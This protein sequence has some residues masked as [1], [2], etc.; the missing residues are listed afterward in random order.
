M[1]DTWRI[2]LEHQGFVI[3]FEEPSDF[4][5]VQA[6]RDAVGQ[7]LF[8]LIDNAIK[9]SGDSKHIEV[10]LGHQDHQAVIEVVDQG[11]GISRSEQKHIFDRFHRV[12]SGLAHDVKGSGLGLALVQHIAS[13]HGGRVTVSS[14]LGQGSTFALHLPLTPRPAESDVELQP[15]GAESV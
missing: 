9:Y 11:I 12:G 10:R 15:L 8:N 6:D 4:P 1:L 13:A 14:Q 5:T 2:R 7:A 3:D